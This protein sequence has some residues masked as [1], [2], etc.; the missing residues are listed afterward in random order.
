MI[1]DHGIASCKISTTYSM[2]A[3][4]DH[5]IICKYPNIDDCYFVFQLRTW[6]FEACEV[7]D[8]K[9]GNEEGRRK[10]SL[11]AEVLA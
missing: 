3:E 9:Q 6:L 1:F 4:L 7:K 11:D 5:Q 2:Q 8:P 10:Y